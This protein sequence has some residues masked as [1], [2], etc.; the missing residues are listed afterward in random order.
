[1]GTAPPAVA[2]P[3][4]AGAS[5]VDDAALEP[6]AASRLAG[7]A[8]GESLFSNLVSVDVVSLPGGGGRVRAEWGGV[9]ALS[10]R[11][12]HHRGFDGR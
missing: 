12:H 5:R 10:L 2:A 4:A 11:R 3:S 7:L 8:D 1:M 9:L 6:A